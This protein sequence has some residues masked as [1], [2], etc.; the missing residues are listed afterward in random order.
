MER[1]DAN[2]DG[3]I[4]VEESGFVLVSM[5]LRQGVKAEDCRNMISRVDLDGNGK[6][7]F[8]EFKKMNMAATKGGKLF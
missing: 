8:E 2:G 7:N 5:G 6:V 4:D 1:V 3:L